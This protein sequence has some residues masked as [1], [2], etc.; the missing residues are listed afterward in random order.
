MNNMQLQLVSDGK[1]LGSVDLKPDVQLMLRAYA[2]A[3]EVPLMNMI[4]LAIRCAI[5]PGDELELQ[6]PEIFLSDFHA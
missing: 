3:N 6:C 5:G 4:D 1:T 2:K